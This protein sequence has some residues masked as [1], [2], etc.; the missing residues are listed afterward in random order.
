[1]RR[2]KKKKEEEEK[3]GGEKGKVQHSTAHT[4][5]HANNKTIRESGGKQKMATTRESTS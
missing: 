1:M 3:R 2:G 5:T 4:F